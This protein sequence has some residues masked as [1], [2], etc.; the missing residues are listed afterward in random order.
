MKKAGIIA[1]G[2][3]AGSAQAQTA[4]NIYGIVD[5][6]IVGESGGVAKTTKLTS[7]AGAFSRL[8]F[9]GSEDLGDGLSAYFILESGIRIDSG[10][11]D[12]TGSIFNRQALVGLKGKAGSVSLGRQYTPWHAT[13]A[14]IADPFANG[15]AGSTKNLFPDWGSNVRTSNTIMVASPIVNG[16]SGDL[17]YSAGE[18]STLSAGRQYGGSIGYAGGPLVV[19]LAYNARNADVVP[20]TGTPTLHDLGRNTLL[21]ANYA[22]K[23]FKLYAAY[24]IDKGY[25]SAPLG[26]TSNPYGGVPAT[27]STDSN[28]ALLGLTAPIGSGTL[29]FSVMHKNDKTAFNQDANA[30]GIGYLYMLSRRTGLYAAYAHIDNK[31]G[32]GYTVANNSESGT[33]STGYNLGIR[34]SF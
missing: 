9:K 28:E 1:L 31:N 21:A 4:V 6:A 18:Q 7:G 12:T 5:A 30:W 25:N 3:L 10:A 20:A 19:R 15:Y 34:H 26:N 29:M 24:G 32:A 16:F 8:G 33:G 2:I 13:L 27:P 14:A 23:A 17:A 22:F 11:V